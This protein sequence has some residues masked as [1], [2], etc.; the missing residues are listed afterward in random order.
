MN[1]RKPNKTKKYY[2]GYYT[3]M[4]KQKYIGNPQ[5]VTYRSRWEFFFMQ[6][7]DM[8]EQIVKWGS[9]VVTIPYQDEKGGF[10]RYYPDFYIEMR[11]KNDPEKYQRIVAEIKPK[12]EMKMPEPPK[13]DTLKAYE[14]Y[15]Y[16]LKMFQKN[17]LKWQS[18]KA[19]CDKKGLKFILLNEDHLKESKI[20]L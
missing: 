18:A 5:K 2:Q 12:N 4:N 3:L 7:C 16:Q 6:Y 9:E 14:S 1:N 20:M 11:D 8:N 13:K 15:E 10:H 17:I 19:F